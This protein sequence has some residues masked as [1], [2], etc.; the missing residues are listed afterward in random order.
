[1]KYIKYESYDEIYPYNYA[2]WLKNAVLKSKSY[3]F[4]YEKL[5]KVIY[6]E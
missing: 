4:Q 3:D 1:M 5:L 2:R 6:N